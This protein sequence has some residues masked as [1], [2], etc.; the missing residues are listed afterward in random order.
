MGVEAG[1]ERSEIPHPRFATTLV[2]QGRAEAELLAAVQSAQLH[3]A[4]LIGGPDGIG[5]A[6]LAYR[7]ARYLLAAPRERHSTGLLSVDSEGAT[8]RQVSAGAHPNLLVLERAE[9]AATGG[10]RTIPV[11][12]V[13]RTLAFFGHT[14]ANGAH[15]VCIV[16]S[17]EAVTVQ[18]LN[19]LLKTLEE[20]PPRATILV[21][22]HAPH[23]VL[24]TIRS[25]CRKLAAGSLTSE[26]VT[27]VVSGLAPIFAGDTARL[28]RAAERA[29]GSVGRALKL[30]EPRR[31]ALL[32]Q[33]ATLLDALPRVPTD[34]LL[35]LAA[36]VAEKS[37][38]DDLGLVVNAITSWASGRMSDRAG[39]GPALLAPLAEVC[40]KI[41]DAARSVETYNLD[42]RVFVVS[43]F[44]DLSAAVKRSA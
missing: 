30:M 32:D 38:V 13:R 31:A 23:R 9:L 42:R 41:F 1:D 22:S 7:F 27:S 11:E 35:A 6:T 24:A 29:E 18:G 3:H 34:D 44:A 33:L 25:R 15:R 2:G 10:G 19:A 17:A 20:P 4:W 40:E 21:V 14:A 12:A 36:K 37:A 26:E 5:K 16:D 8:F 28:A 43:T 39:A